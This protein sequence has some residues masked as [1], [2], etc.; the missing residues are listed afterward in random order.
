MFSEVRRRK[1]QANRLTVVA[2]PEIH[3]RPIEPHLRLLL[4]LTICRR[5]ALVRV[6]KYNAVRSYGFEPV[7]V[8]Q[9]CDTADE[10]VDAQT[11]EDG[12]DC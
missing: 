5:E 3:K 8:P 7:V 4:A 9:M 12:V 6:R 1:A 2:L 11:G 10:E